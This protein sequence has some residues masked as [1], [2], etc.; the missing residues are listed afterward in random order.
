MGNSCGSR[1]CWASR[2]GIAGCFFGDYIAG[3]PFAY[4]HLPPQFYGVVFGAGIVA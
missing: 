3:S 4:H 1:G 2:A